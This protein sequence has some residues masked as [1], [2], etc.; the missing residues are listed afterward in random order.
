MVIRLDR[1]RSDES[2]ALQ[3]AELVLWRLR[4]QTAKKDLM[5]EYAEARAEV[6][7]ARMRW[8]ELIYRG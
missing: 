8:M 3:D 5:V 4:R 1:Q 6:G 2:L 7:Q